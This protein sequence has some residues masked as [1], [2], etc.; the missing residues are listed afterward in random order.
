MA[1]EE[2]HQNVYNIM[3]GRSNTRFFKQGQSKN[4]E[5]IVHFT[6]DPRFEAHRSYQ[7]PE[8]YRT[9]SFAQ[10]APTLNEPTSLPAIQTTR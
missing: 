9:L 1:T 6:K 7:S 8:R 2:N 4:G 3:V 10:P 5:D